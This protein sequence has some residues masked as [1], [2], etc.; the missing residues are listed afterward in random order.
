M[1][2]SHLLAIASGKGGVGKTW[3][4]ATLAHT[5][6]HPLV[7][8]LASPSAQPPGRPRR[9][10]LLLDADLGLA[11]VDIQLGLTPA[12]DLADVLAGRADLAGAVATHA[13]GGFDILAG[14]SGS[15]A[16]ATLDGAAL[17]GFC[18][19]VADARAAYDIVILDLGAGVDRTVRRLAALA[20]TLVVLATEEPTSITDAYAVV[21]LHGADCPGGDR[22]VVVNQASSP[23]SGART[24]AV[25]ARAA[26]QFL[27]SAPPLAGV[28]RR[29]PAVPAAIRRQ[30]LLLSLHPGS[31]AAADMRALAEPLLRPAVPASIP[32][33]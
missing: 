18:A 32:A 5:L 25:L 20:D 24:Y 1:K 12:R 15:G 19:V 21:K 6:A 14:R 11:N 31:R 9:R 28:I 7:H 23:A 29:D 10:I 17:A 8:P 4:A 22:R 27:G 13:E 16:L 33:A 3:F 30:S 2:A 26:R